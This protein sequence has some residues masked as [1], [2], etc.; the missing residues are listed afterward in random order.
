MI[1]DFTRDVRYAVRGLRRA[2]G[3]ALAVIAAIGLGIGLNTTLFTVF[4]AY[5][6]RPHAVRDPYS[7][8]SFV[9]F[10]KG[11]MGRFLKLEENAP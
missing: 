6:L 1:D 8:H 4:N 7:L 2:P 11:S 5:V 10:E 3:F 9:V